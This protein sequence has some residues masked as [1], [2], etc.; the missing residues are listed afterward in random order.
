MV[1][2][3]FWKFSTSSGF[4]L[5]LKNSSSQK[6]IFFPFIFKMA[7]HRLLTEPCTGGA[8]LWAKCNENRWWPCNLLPIRHHHHS[9]LPITLM[10]LLLRLQSD[11]PVE[12]CTAGLCETW[13]GAA[14]L[15]CYLAIFKMAPGRLLMEP[16]TGDSRF[17]DELSAMR[18]GG[19]HVTL[20]RFAIT[21]FCPLLWSVVCW[22]CRVI[23]LWKSALRDYMKRE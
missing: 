5:V 12:E 1:I 23:F 14:G 17:N 10:S 18:I 13:I 4:W 22:G 2:E 7:P 3:Q 19:D 11:I 6:P 15:S 9:F 16:C 21:H 20:C 8:R